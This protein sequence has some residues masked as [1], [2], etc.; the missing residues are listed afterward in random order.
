MKS[1]DALRGALFLSGVISMF[2]TCW[3]MG[4]VVFAGIVLGLFVS[5]VCFIL[6][7]LVP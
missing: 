3:L 7:S 2:T 6:W 5:V 1:N 4:G